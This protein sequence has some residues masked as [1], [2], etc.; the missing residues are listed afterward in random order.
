MS[1]RPA[2]E[3]VQQTADIK[4]IQSGRDTI[5]GDINKTINQYI[6]QQNDWVE[7]E[8]LEEYK[9]PY[10]PSPINIELL[11]KQILNQR[12][13]VLGGDHEDKSDLALHLAVKLRDLLLAHSGESNISIWEWSSISNT[14]SLFAGIR[15][16]GI[17]E[18][19]RNRNAPAILFLPEIQP[20]HN[21]NQISQAAVTGNSYVIATAKTP[22]DKWA[23]T[24]NQRR[25]FCWE[26]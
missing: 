11:L 7:R 18:I 6:Q 19:N 24:D 3:N 4:D 13:L 21:L 25:S 12:L 1:A 26:P 8:S 10:F 16:E 17:Q 23:V 15:R 20:Q 2:P 14:Q 5:I 22:V 9:S